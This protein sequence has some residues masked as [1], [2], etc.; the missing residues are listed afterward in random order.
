M[1]P[2]LSQTD[3]SLELE[4]VLFQHMVTNCIAPF[5]IVFS[6]LFNYI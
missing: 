6:Y 2:H 3:F 4:T 1:S 5:Y